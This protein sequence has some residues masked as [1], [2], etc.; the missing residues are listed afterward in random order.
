MSPIFIFL[1]FCFISHSD[2]FSIHSKST[3]SDPF[4]C[5]R[6]GV[7]NEHSFFDFFNEKTTEK[8]TQIQPKEMP[9][10]LNLRL[11]NKAFCGKSTIIQTSRIV[12]GKTAILGQF[13]WQAQIWTQKGFE[14]SPTFTC[15]G[16]LINEGLILTAAHCIQFT[17][18]ERYSVILGRQYVEDKD[19]ACPSQNRYQV[20]LILTIL[21]LDFVSFRLHFPF[22]FEI[23]ETRLV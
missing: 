12:G 18:P 21:G 20:S 3:C 7:Q 9:P 22:L 2:E 6:D 8:P 4:G 23:G 13:P 10:E 16:S 15:G 14:K 17:N 1:T 11:E 19:E 5:A